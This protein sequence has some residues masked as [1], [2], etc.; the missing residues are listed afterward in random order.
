MPMNWRDVAPLAAYINRIGAQQLNFR[1]FMVKENRG[2]YYVERCFITLAA[3][4]EITC[5]N[6]EYAPTEEEATAIKAA[7]LA[8]N[9]D[10][11]TWVKASPAKLPELRALIG[12]NDPLYEFYERGTDT[13]IMVQQ[14]ARQADGRKQYRPWSYWSDGLWRCMEPDCKL[15][16]W[17]PRFSTN[18]RRIMM[19]E[20]AKPAAAIHDLCTN[21]ARQP[22]LDCHPWRDEIVEYEHWGVIGGALAPSRTTFDDI[23]VERPLELVY[24]CDNDYAGKDALKEISKLV[25]YPLKGVMFDNAWPVAWDMADPMPASMYSG[26]RWIGLALREYM[27]PATWA[28]EQRRSGEGKPYMAIRKDFAEEWLHCVSP[29]VYVHQEWS[30]SIHMTDEFNNLMA[31][32]SD[33]KDTAALLKKSGVSKTAVLKYD[34]GLAPG[35]YTIEGERYINTHKPSSVRV[36]VGDAGPWLDFM[37]HL[38]PDAGDRDHLLRWCATLIAK[39]DIKMH[40]GVLLISE[41]QGVGKGTLGERV[42]GPLLGADNVSQPSEQDICKS[43]FNYWAAHKRLAV[44]HE[45]YAGHSAQA[46]NRLKSIVTDRVIVINK[47]YQ[48]E[49]L[50]DNWLHIF[51]CSNSM[52]ALKLDMEDRRW[53]IPAIGSDKRSPTYW[54]TFNGWLTLEGGLGKI[55][56]WAAQ[57][58]AQHGSVMVGDAAPWTSAKQEVVDELSS[59]GKRWVEGFLKR[60]KIELVEEQSAQV[61]MLDV[62]L[63]EGIKQFVHD[64]RQVDYLERPQTIRKLAKDKGWHV[65]EEYVFCREWNPRF[66]KAR[67]IASTPELANMTQ[68]AEANGRTKLD[69]VAYGRAWS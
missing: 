29:E 38:V 8:G 6:E 36:E 22:E 15:P 50:I 5:N 53:L 52:R 37:E 48:S 28:T 16:I 51:A 60:A 14:R 64:G 13:I 25:K 57:W 58:V 11:P 68:V 33:V 42:L 21:P 27:Q 39:P 67:I 1:K 40:Y 23:K 59:P 65:G 26:S 24:I 9:F 46:Y 34:P 2:N 61:F 4:G 18:K 7:F 62:D 35:V 10:I 45:I 69:V 63:V 41:T 47:K 32:Y 55:K 54:Q 3:D 43:D 44:V 31:P 66:A 19:H 30:N 20:G 17:K 49:Y 56:H 12:N